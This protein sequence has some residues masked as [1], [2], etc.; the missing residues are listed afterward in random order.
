MASLDKLQTLIWSVI[1]EHRM[2]GT[3]AMHDQTLRAF[4]ALVDGN[5]VPLL[6]VGNGR[7]QI[8][9]DISVPYVVSNYLPYADSGGPPLEIAVG[10]KPVVFGDFMQMKVRIVRQIRLER[11]NEKFAEYHQAA[12]IANRSADA[13]LLRSTQT[14]NCPIKYLTGA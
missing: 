2:R 5:D 14:A 7:L 4:A 1:N 6:G 9:K 12:F 3:I 13:D 8:A 11:M 10:E